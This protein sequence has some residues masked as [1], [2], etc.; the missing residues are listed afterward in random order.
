MEFWQDW[1][2]DKSFALLQ[3]LRKKYRFI[4]IGG[5]AVYFLTHTLKSKD[6]DIIVD[7]EELEKM[8]TELKIGK[9][10]FLKKYSCEIEGISIDIYVPYYSKLAIPPEEIEKNTIT[11]EG[12]R[13]PKPEI[14]LILKQQAEMERKHSM[15]GEKDRVD[16]LSLLLSGKID[17]E[18]YRKFVEK[19]KL[20]NYSKRLYEIISRA[21]KEFEY[22]GIK[23]PREIKKLKEIL[24]KDL[25]AFVQK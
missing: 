18:K 5:W 1:V 14:L 4:L 13:I 25:K 10:E 15:K 24:L 7:Y 9:T 17:F 3:S 12:F 11:I 8:K 22:L 21:R 19:F 6:I 16:I 23:N 2:I 20:E